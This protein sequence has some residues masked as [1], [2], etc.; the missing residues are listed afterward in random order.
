[1]KIDLRQSD[2]G[3]IMPKMKH[4]IPCA[5]CLYTYSKSYSSFKTHVCQEVVLMDLYAPD[6]LSEEVFLFVCLL[7]FL[8]LKALYIRLGVEEMFIK[9]FVF[10]FF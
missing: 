2:T 10:L 7:L 8:A 9:L 6:A 4:A 3:E 5:H 1:M